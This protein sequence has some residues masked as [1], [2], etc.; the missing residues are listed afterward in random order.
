LSAVAE[1]AFSILEQVARSEQPLGLME[2]AT[3]LDTDKSAALRSLAFLEE[4]GMLR[5]DS[6]SKKYRIGPGLLSLSAI[7]IR[8]ADL[9]QVA[10]PYLA[11]LRDLTGETVSLHVRVGDERVC[12]AGA[13]SP[14]VIQRVL[15][16][17]EP[18]SL[19]LGP[20]GKVILAFLAEADRVAIVARAK[21][22]S[23]GFERELVRARRD[24]YLI[25]M[26]DRTAGVG[27]ISTPVFDAHGA[28]AAITI[29]GP[30]ERLTPP[31]MEAVAGALVE[32]AAAVSAE[33]GG[34]HP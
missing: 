8:K 28:V 18:V 17:G 4:R 26:S 7:A 25:V 6:G 27:A 34:T 29:A 5:R 1:R 3:R 10:Q 16:V 14:H 21:A 2:L 32:A 22:S 30:E 19:C 11:R 9:P 13:E 33:I 24:G 23:P 12:I 15:T 31:G 20:T